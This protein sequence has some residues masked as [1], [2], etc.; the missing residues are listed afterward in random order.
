M[1]TL[2]RLLKV[3]HNLF[4]IY[5]I[6]KRL[7]QIQ[8]SLILFIDGIVSFKATSEGHV[9]GPS[10]PNKYTVNEDDSNR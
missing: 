5:S 6:K 4:V 3:D 7:S 2:K 8:N 1:R 9:P 10:L